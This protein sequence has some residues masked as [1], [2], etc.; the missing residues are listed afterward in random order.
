MELVTEEKKVSEP[1]SDG[2]FDGTASTP[3]PSVHELS[4][5]A[6]LGAY[7]DYKKMGTRISLI[8]R[9]GRIRVMCADETRGEMWEGDG[10]LLA[11]A[12]TDAN[13]GQA[14]PS[15]RFGY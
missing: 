7:Y 10:D 9:E 11:K 12:V 8:P 15:W 3:H 5:F 13:D 1:S 4:R 6:F 2:V 14:W